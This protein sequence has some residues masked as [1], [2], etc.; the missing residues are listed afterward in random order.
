MPSP[1]F[2]SLVCEYL[3]PLFDH[4]LEDCFEFLMNQNFLQLN[5]KAQILLDVVRPLVYC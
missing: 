3:K 4:F 2:S 5:L 1:D